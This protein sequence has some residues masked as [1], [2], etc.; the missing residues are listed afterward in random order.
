MTRSTKEA[1]KKYCPFLEHE[2]REAWTHYRH[3]ENDRT[4]YLGYFF[5]VLTASMGFLLILLRGNLPWEDNTR[6]LIPGIFSFVWIIT[7]LN[8]YILLFIK[9]TEF[10]LQHYHKVW[11]GIRK[12]VYD[13]PD[14]MHK[15]LD[16]QDF[17]PPVMIPLFSNQYISEKVL[18]LFMILLNVICICLLSMAFCYK[19]YGFV[20]MAYFFS[21][22]FFF[23]L[24][25][26]V[27]FLE[28]YSQ[29]KSLKR[30][31]P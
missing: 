3:I 21:F 28:V 6:W 12:L 24:Y 7:V 8:L 20:F 15:I 29:K 5:G 22:F 26:F 25:V 27:K 16:F 31:C 30:N 18:V 1:E 2:F 19:S 11:K 13:D 9:K 4:K 10:I 23:E 17:Y 14:E